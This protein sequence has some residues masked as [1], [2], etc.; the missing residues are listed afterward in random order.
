[1]TPVLPEPATVPTPSQSMSATE[2]RG[3]YNAIV[4]GRLG[5]LGWL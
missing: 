1:M 2:G 5:R 4:I 3:P